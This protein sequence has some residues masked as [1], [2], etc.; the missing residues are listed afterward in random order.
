MSTVVALVTEEGAWIGADSRATCEDGEIRPGDAEK[1]FMN[2]RYIIGF[3]GSVRGGQILLPEYFDAPTTLADWP[4]AI[5]EQS[6]LKG[7]LGQSE[8]QTSLML[9][10]YVI[11]DTRTGKV[12]EMLI[13]FQFTEVKEYTCVGSGG[14]YAFGSLHTTE[15]LNIN[16]E[17]RVKMALEAAIKF[18]RASGGP[19]HIFKVEK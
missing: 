17:E 4:D 14:P 13:D 19:I 10:N 5:I 15:E 3:I 18:D 7:C 8:Q 2:D 16:G 11:G 1:I 9:C 6:E 12:Y